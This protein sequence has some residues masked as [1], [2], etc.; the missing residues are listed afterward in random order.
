M[1]LGRARK[2]LLPTL[3]L[4]VVPL[5]AKVV[6]VEISSRTD[7]LNGRSFGDAGAFERIAGRVY[8]SVSASNR[9]NRAIVDLTNAV[10]L[11]KG[12]V[13]FSSDFVAICPK[14]ARKGNGSLILEVPNR[15]YGRIIALVDGGDWNVARDAGD[16]WLLNKGYTVVT[17]GWQW[18]A[19]GENSLRLFA[20]IAK[21]NGET[22]TGLLRGDYMPWNV[23]SQIP[24]GHFFSRDGIGGSEIGRAHV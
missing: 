1:L 8:F 18:D 6:R 11:K 12:E 5:N 20:P 17:L 4:L 14:D 13:E 22:I 16:A 9:H 24:L 15:G 19:T 10:N 7:V 3:L 23:R 2:A 21:Q